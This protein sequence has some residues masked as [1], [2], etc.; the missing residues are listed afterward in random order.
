MGRLNKYHADPEVHQEEFSRLK[1]IR[2]IVVACFCSWIARIQTSKK[3]SM[4]KNKGVIYS[5]TLSCQIRLMMSPSKYSSMRD[6]TNCSTDL[7]VRV[8]TGIPSSPTWLQ[9]RAISKK[10][11]M[12]SSRRKRKKKTR[13]N[14]RSKAARINSLPSL[15]SRAKMTPP[16]S[17]PLWRTSLRIQRSLTTSLS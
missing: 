12:F 13:W 16:G 2:S 8:S 11:K 4:L 1:T 9:I 6:F 15:S 7:T 3:N 10:N 14:E 17:F 5:S